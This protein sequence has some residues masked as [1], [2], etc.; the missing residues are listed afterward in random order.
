MLEDLQIKFLKLEKQKIPLLEELQKKNIILRRFIA[1]GTLKFKANIHEFISQ[2]KNL[3][4]IIQRTK[5][6]LVRAKDT[7]AEN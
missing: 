2:L 5:E 7:S 6:C 4:S 3:K 1:K